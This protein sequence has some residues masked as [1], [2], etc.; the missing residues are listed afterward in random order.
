[1]VIELFDASWKCSIGGTLVIF[2]EM[3]RNPDEVGEDVR[4]E[5]VYQRVC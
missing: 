1:M 5:K 4:G 3:I 2:D